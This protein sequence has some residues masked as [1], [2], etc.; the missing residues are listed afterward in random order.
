[1]NIHEYQARQLLSQYGVSLPIAEAFTD[2]EAARQFAAGLFAKGE[3]MVVIK[4]QIHAGGRGKGTFK[5]GYKGGV[6][7]CKTPAEAKEIAAKCPV[8]EF[9]GSVEVRPMQDVMR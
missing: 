1:M 2:P 5:N 6:H 8:F 3:K 9:Q 7:L 4:S